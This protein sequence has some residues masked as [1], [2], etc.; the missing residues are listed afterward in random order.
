MIYTKILNIYIYNFFFKK[1]KKKKRII[2]IIQFINLIYI[3]DNLN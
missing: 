3:T 2:I 1:K